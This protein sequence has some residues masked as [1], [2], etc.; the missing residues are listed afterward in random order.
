MKEFVVTRVN[1]TGSEKYY[2]AIEPRIEN[3]GLIA[4]V[5]GNYN[6]DAT[7]KIYQH[8]GYWVPKFTKCL[9][10]KKL[11]IGT[12]DCDELTSTEDPFADGSSLECSG[13][14]E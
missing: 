7:N 12:A 9:P 1:P 3:G 14:L 10:Y 13:P 5:I 6:P 2:L 11:I 4:T 8:T